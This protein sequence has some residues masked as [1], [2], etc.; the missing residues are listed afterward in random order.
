MAR[1][2]VEMQ[3]KDFLPP[4]RFGKLLQGDPIRA[5]GFH[6][7][8][9]QCVHGA[10]ASSKLLGTRIQNIAT[11]RLWN[12]Q[13]MPGAARHNIHKSKGLIVFVDLE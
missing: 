3:M 4:C 9:G 8:V 10:H 1:Q 13:T 7:A 2:N 5:K 6:S 12:N 11:W